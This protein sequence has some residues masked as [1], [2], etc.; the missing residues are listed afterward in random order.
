MSPPA[1]PSGVLTSGSQTGDVAAEYQLSMVLADL[2]LAVPPET[3]TALLPERANLARAE[4]TLPG[5]SG[6]RLKASTARAEKVLTR[7]DFAD[8]DGDLTETSDN[9]APPVTTATT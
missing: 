5:Y 4:R 2:P 9:G 8:W 3:A 7:L 6:K 1:V